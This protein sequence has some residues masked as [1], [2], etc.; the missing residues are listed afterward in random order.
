M[1]LEGVILII[2]TVSRFQFCVYLEYSASAGTD[3]DAGTNSDKDEKAKTKDGVYL[4]S[5]RRR[6]RLELRY[7]DGTRERQ[8]VLGRVHLVNTVHIIQYRFLVIVAARFS[9]RVLHLSGS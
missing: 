2:E 9:F 7:N 3:E 5:L 8:T 6:K 4:K 1:K